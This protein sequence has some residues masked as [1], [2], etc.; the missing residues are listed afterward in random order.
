MNILKVGHLNAVVDGSSAGS[1]SVVRPA[2]VGFGPTAPR[3]PDNGLA[4]P[5]GGVSLVRPSVLRVAATNQDAALMGEAR[6]YFGRQ[7]P[8]VV[9]ALQR[10]HPDLP[11]A[12]VDEIADEWVLRSTRRFGAYLEGHNDGIE[13][14]T[15][16]G[17][18]LTIAYEGRRPAGD[19][20]RVLADAHQAKLIDG[21]S[22]GGLTRDDATFQVRTVGARLSRSTAGWDA[23]RA[24][25][26]PDSRI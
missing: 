24:A 14:L 1:E 16:S 15:P 26:R 20:V 7:R 13:S 17:L 4:Q 10:A 6:A 9:N 8:D 22:R 25:A 5:R 19:P 21:F 3:L 23:E 2:M 18:L 11:M 12:V